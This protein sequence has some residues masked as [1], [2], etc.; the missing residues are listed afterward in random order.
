MSIL[1]KFENY[2]S[3]KTIAQNTITS[4]YSRIKNLL[5][6]YPGLESGIRENDLNVYFEN[7]SVTPSTRALTVHAANNFNKMIGSGIR[8]K[9]NKIQYGFRK[10]SELENESF[11]FNLIENT[12]SQYKDPE[13]RLRTKALIYLLYYTGIRI[14]EAV[15]IKMKDIDFVKNQI[16]IPEQKSKDRTIPMNK[17]LVSAL[18]EY[19]DFAESDDEYIFLS[20]GKN[21][22]NKQLSYGGIRHTVK[23]V[24][25]DSG[26]KSQSCHVFRYVF[27]SN[28]FKKGA[29]IKDIQEITGHTTY[30]DLNHYFIGD[31]SGLKAIEEL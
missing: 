10:Q 23:K 6:E 30:G 21:H 25:I 14:G 26:Y 17:N 20:H 9:S 7:K 11:D 12:I 18:K 2:L 4:Y 22:K 28:L 31:K 3:G 19:L 16:F 27:I 13:I 5:D 8:L 1:I 24:L 15:N 29:F